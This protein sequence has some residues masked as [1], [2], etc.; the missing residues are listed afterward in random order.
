MK[1]RHCSRPLSREFIDLGSAPP[2]NA[3]IEAEKLAEM[4]VWLPLRVVVCDSC[5]LVQTAD[6]TAPGS[7]FDRNYAY[8]SS[9]SSSWLR[10]AEDY[11]EAMVNRLNLDANSRVVEIASNDGYLLQFIAAR[12]IPCLGVEPTQSTAAAARAKGISVVE[13]FFGRALADR[14]AS[15]F[16]K[17]DLMV[18]NNVLAHVPCID[19][20]VGG[21]ANLL[22]DKGVATFEFPSLLSL[23][24]GQQFDT[25]YHEHYSYLSLNAVQRIFAANGLSVFD[26]ENLATH[27]GSLRVF[28]ER[29]E[30]RQRPQ[31]AI[32]AAQLASEEEAGVASHEF[33]KGFQSQAESIKDEFVRF[34]LDAKRDGKTVCAYGAAA[35]GNTLLNFAGVRPDLLP[36]VVDRSPGKLGKHLPGS[37][38]PIVSEDRIAAEQPDFVVILPW[39][40]RAEIVEQLSYVRDWS[41]RFVTAVPRLEVFE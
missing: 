20:F 37:R 34:L 33:Y 12:G 36:F 4:E 8:F 7:L 15:D 39:N 14:I 5:W 10:H 25:I 41:G 21:F 29:T 19:D 6:F 27:G 3:Y 28:A 38:I 35:K 31:T 9:V 32:L 1:C 26:I 30:T 17:A 22:S 16:G 11:V 2:S 13:E 23:V 24:N 18:A 40:L